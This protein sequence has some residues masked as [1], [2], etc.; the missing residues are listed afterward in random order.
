MSIPWLVR[1]GLCFAFLSAFL[2]YTISIGITAFLPLAALAF[3]GLLVLSGRQRTERLQHILS[4]GALWFAAVLFAEV[5]SYTSHDTYSELYGLVFIGV[6]LCARLVVQEIGIPNVMRA[7]SQAG[8]LT[9]CVILITGRQT[10][11]AGEGRFAGGTRAHPNLVSFVMA[12]FFPVII[13]RAME[14]RVRWRKRVLIGLSIATFG[15]IF[16]TGSRGSLSAVLIAAGAMLVRALGSGWLRK[17]RI[18][19]LHIMAALILIPLGT[20]LL[21]QHNRI[22]NIVS[23]LNDFLSLTSNQR[24]L[25]SGLSGRTGIWQLAF[26][27]LRAHNRWLFGFGYRAGDRLVGTIDNGYVQL[28]FESGLIAG[29][30]ILGSMLRV[31]FLLWRVSRPIENNAWTRYYMMLW[32][33]MIVYFLNNISTRYLFSFGSPFSLCVLCLMA[34]S[35]RELIGGGMRELVTQKV[36]PSP[37]AATAETLAWNRYG[38]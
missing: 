22:G 29:L 10:L 1:T 24:G 4:G 18:G 35:R 38:R 5:V 20:A 8:I 27:I 3:C 32:C 17:I 31:F 30:M 12:G 7:Y 15:L 34:A 37:P 28:L 19:H 36:K 23:Y 14:E 16:L 9:A 26:S 6:F 13:W 25:K 2:Q 33:L 21:L 11:F